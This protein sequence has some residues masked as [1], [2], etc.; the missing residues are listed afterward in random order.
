MADRFA[1]GAQSH[2]VEIASN[3][4]YMLQYFIAMGVP[5]MGS[6]PAANVAATAIAKGVP[7]EIAFFGN[8]TA[9][10][11]VD[12]GW[13]AD[14]LAAKNVL[15]HVPDINDFV[16]GVRTI[17]KP[18]DV[19][20]VEFPHLLNLIREVQ[21]D[22]IYHEHFTY[23]SVLAV[24]T[25][26]ER[27][28]LKVID[29]TRQP[30][31]GGSLRVFMARTESGHGIA[32]GVQAVLDDEIAAG[33]NRPEGY[34]GFETRVQAVRAGLLAFLADVRAKGESIAAYGAA[35]K[36][37]T[38][39]N[40][41]GVTAADIPFVVDRNPAKQDRLLPGSH[42]PVRPVEKLVAARPD[43]VLI[44]PWNIRDEVIRQV[45]GLGR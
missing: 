7:T 41:C 19:F 38:L 12:K 22:T 25:I 6:E 9:H 14:L 39:L 8:S 45:A 32:A 27:Q 26:A 15:A 33:L 21:F 20:T 30:T 23:L 31:H 37:N 43:H 11:M 13:A 36:G 4:G 35:A 16:A 18:E 44:L 1:L 24:K 5:V 40:Y 2:V 3:D 29:V 42:I 10:A 17:L 28:G 34:A